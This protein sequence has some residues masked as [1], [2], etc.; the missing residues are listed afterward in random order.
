[1]SGERTRFGPHEVRNIC[2]VICLLLLTLASRGRVAVLTLIFIVWVL[3]PFLLLAVFDRVSRSWTNP[4]RSVVRVMTVV[5]PVGNVIAYAQD[6]VWPRA[7]QRAFV[8]TIT[9]PVSLLAIAIPV[10]VTALATRN[11]NRA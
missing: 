6:A 2:G 3:L 1:M 9:P 11:R 4:C 8:W 5:V 10:L 7:A